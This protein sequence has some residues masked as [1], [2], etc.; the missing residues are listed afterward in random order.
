MLRERASMDLRKYKYSHFFVDETG[1]DQVWKF[2]GNPNHAG[3]S[4]MVDGGLGLW[5]GIFHF[6]CIFSTNYL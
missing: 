3:V 4:A 2:D 6:N 5:E 1:S